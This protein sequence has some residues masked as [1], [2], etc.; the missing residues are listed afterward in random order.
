MAQRAHHE[1]DRTLHE[2]F[3]RRIKTQT[4]LPSADTAA[5]LFWALL[6]SG[7]IN[8]RKVDGWQSLATKPI[9]Q[10][11]GGD[12][13]PHV[14][15]PRLIRLNQAGRLSFDGLIT[16]EFPLDDINAALDL[17]RSGAAGRVLVN[18]AQK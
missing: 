14:D 2:E 9:D 13:V 6:A 16:H 18:I 8:M 12:A 15:I 7:Q 3:K 10:P 11:V 17:V 1:R 4:V 5:M